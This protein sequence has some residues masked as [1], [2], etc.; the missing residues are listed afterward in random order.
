MLPEK[1]SIIV[2][3]ST[4]TERARDNFARIV[5]NIAAFS[6][7]LLVI[8]I[9]I[10]MAALVSY[11]V[12]ERSR[13]DASTYFRQRA[14]RLDLN[15]TE[16]F[17]HYET[18]LRAGQGFWDSGQQVTPEA[19]RTF[20]K[21]VDPVGSETSVMAFGY[22]RK[23]QVRGG[24]VSAKVT[25]AEPSLASLNMLGKDLMLDKT[26]NEGIR[27]CVRNKQPS[28]T[29]VYPKWLEKY[30]GYYLFLV[31]PAKHQAKS[32]YRPA[33]DGYVFLIL[34][35][36][37]LM[38]GLVKA[39]NNDLSLQLFLRKAHRQG[40]PLYQFTT[41]EDLH[42][43]AIVDWRP[44]NMLGRAIEA[45]IFASPDRLTNG[46]QNTLFAFLGGLLLS[47]L[48]ASI[49]WNLQTTRHRAMKLAKTMTASLREREK[50]ASKLALIAKL[51]DNAV[52]VCNPDGYI[53]WTN[54]ALTKL[55][56]ISPEACLDKPFIS[57]L[58]DSEASRF[59]VD[60]VEE[61][62]SALEPFSLEVRFVQ[63][64]N[65]PLW[66]VINGT[67]AFGPDGKLEHFLAVCNDVTDQKLAR[68]EIEALAKL[69]EESPNPALRI[70]RSG[71]ITY[72]NSA[73]ASFVTTDPELVATWKR[74]SKDCLMEAARREMEIDIANRTWIMSFV[75]ATGEGYVNIYNRDI[76]ERVRAERELV[77][78]REKAIEASRLKSE[79]LAN[80]SH[81]IRTPMNGVLGMV[82]LLL[83]TDLSDHQK[84]YAQTILSSADSL[85]VIINDILDFSKIEAGKLTIES[86]DFDLRRLVEETVE[87]FSPSAFAKDIEVIADI[88]PTVNTELAGDPIRIKQI[89]LNLLSNAI[90]FTES[91][92]V[93]VSAHTEQLRKES[94]DLHL[95]VEDSGIGIPEHRKNA[96]FESFTQA[97]G[98][99]TRKYGGTGLGLA[100]SQQLVAL[101]GGRIELDS[102]IGR[103]SKFTVRLPLHTR[104]IYAEMA[105]QRD[106]FKGTK[107]H[108]LTKETRVGSAATR[109]MQHWGCDVEV[110]SPLSKMSTDPEAIIV[111]EIEAVENLDAIRG[112]R[113]IILIRPGQQPVNGSDFGAVV[114]K[115]LR[116]SSLRQAL[117]SVKGMATE[118]QSISSKHS[119]LADSLGIRVLVAED[120]P[121][122]QKVASKIL[123]KLGCDVV[124]VSDGKQ[125]VEAVFERPFDLVLMDVQMPI[126]DGLQATRDI[127]AREK[128]TGKRARIV[129]LTANAMAGDED[130]CI[131]AGMDGYLTKP[132][133]AEKLQ[134]AVQLAVDMLARPKPNQDAA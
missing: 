28:S 73:A 67:P 27:E 107:V 99:T 112:P 84:D 4:G 63:A 118:D 6:S 80:M 20:L 126:L 115:P 38:A 29:Q 7:V 59:A 58:D 54:D 47:A 71:Q 16:R 104:D 44:E 23:D 36:R 11:S 132:L 102:A 90:K 32:S 110:V 127:R 10:S 129:A 82:G 114:P 124:V 21:S 56:G 86:V 48:M 100:I 75:P 30:K 69:A 43:G 131:A 92:R 96:I 128:N 33:S 41:P 117:I 17:G 103:G 51:T 134:E 68:Q 108:L 97:D 14:E 24:K 13:A 122:N 9:G 60:E 83:D 105:N 35:V 62:L 111:A 66:M 106:R 22:A 65:R 5:S 46:D 93:V 57:L 19:W 50:E 61:Q 55:T 26:M 77:R 49:V 95:C 25:L 1:P 81:E 42:G 70:D 101:M 53:E 64:K 45:K 91:G 31:M 3:P 34:D 15:M 79:F 125:A 2:P 130:R 109:L 12:Y 119:Q 74:H 89:L 8:V 113:T 40:T 52:I 76:T 37:R 88:S 123:E 116:A 133:R 85:L 94:V 120:N 72:A 87:A 78:A 98:S 121:V 39:S 18:L